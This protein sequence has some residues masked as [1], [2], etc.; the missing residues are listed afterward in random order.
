MIGYIDKTVELLKWTNLWIDW[1][2]V[3]KNTDNLKQNCETQMWHK[4]EK[5]WDALIGTT[6]MEAQSIPRRVL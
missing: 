4:M 6:S 2:T 3:C 1:V 5:N